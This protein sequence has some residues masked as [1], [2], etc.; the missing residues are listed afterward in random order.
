MK[1]LFLF[2]S[3]GFFSC[4]KETSFQTEKIDESKNPQLINVIIDNQTS[5]TIVVR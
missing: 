3:L 2:L 5:K 1:K 4:T